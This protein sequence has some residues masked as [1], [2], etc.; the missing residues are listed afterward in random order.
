MKD[1]CS[2]QSGR[3][4]SL[5]TPETLT[6]A[7]LPLKAEPVIYKPLT[8]FFPSPCL[9][10]AQP[11]GCAS[12]LGYPWRCWTA[13][14]HGSTMRKSRPP[15]FTSRLRVR[16]GRRLASRRPWGLREGGRRRR[17]GSG[18]LLG[19]SPGG[20]RG[21][22]DEPR[23]SRPGAR[24]WAPGLS[25]CG[26]GPSP[27]PRVGW[28]GGGRPGGS[29][30]RWGYG[31]NCGVE[32][33]Q[34]SSRWCFGLIISFAGTSVFPGRRVSDRRR[35]CACVRRPSG[36]EQTDNRAETLLHHLLIMQ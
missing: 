19:G 1:T 12:S 3:K 35:C 26:T 31:Q 6:S 13:F 36:G 11:W 9:K 15:R 24:R 5:R 4:Y 30:P 18:R 2:T 28:G 14:T 8:A 25:A 23:D 32:V 27:Q 22:G 34:A 29:R 21:W 33:A 20:G 7:V 16:A 10:N 17:V